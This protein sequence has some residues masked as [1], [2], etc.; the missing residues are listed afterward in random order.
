M[1]VEVSASLRELQQCAAWSSRCYESGPLAH[2]L[3]HAI[4]DPA[5]LL[6]GDRDAPVRACVRLVLREGTVFGA[7]VTAPRSDLHAVFA[8]AGTVLAGQRYNET[9]FCE[10]DAAVAMA[11]QSSGHERAR[12]ALEHNAILL[13]RPCLTLE[14]ISRLAL[15][16]IHRAHGAAAA[17]GSGSDL[18]AGLRGTWGHDNP[19]V[20]RY[21]AVLDSHASACCAAAPVSGSLAVYN[22]VAGPSGHARN[23]AQAIQ[24]LPWLLPMMTSH[25]SDR[26]R[27]EMPDILA[28]IDGGLPLLDAV[29]EAFDVQREVIR[30]LG[31]RTL[32]DNWL[33]DVRRVRR[34]L[35]L[36][37]WLPPERRPQTPA[38]WRSLKSLAAA[39]SA[40]LGYIAEI[41]LQVTLHRI[42]HCM[43]RWLAQTWPDDHAERAIELLDAQD[44]LRALFE[45]HQSIE[46][47][48]A[49]AADARVLS[50]CARI[51][52]ARVVALSRAWHSTIAAQTWASTT[53]DTGPRWPAVIE[54]PWQDGDRT[55][56]ELTSRE[57]LRSEGQAMAHC[58]GSYAEVCCSGNSVIVS[59][60]SQTGVALS[61]AELHLDDSFPRITAGQH[62]AALNAAPGPGCV[63]ALAALLC[64]LNRAGQ[65]GRL[66]R[67]REFQRAQRADCVC[68]SGAHRFNLFAQEMA[69]RLSSDAACRSLC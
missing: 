2:M 66:L 25:A 51:R 21:R 3:M 47:L 38:A 36:L 37:S 26:N 17:T 27:C 53:D 64:H 43:R 67:R 44:F 24:A 52:I 23:R 58:V 62:R 42:G 1:G 59:L 11:M 18:T 13:P 48:D 33:V 9:A 50:W 12:F 65:H 46:G 61:T 22:F 14:Q 28:A 45:S 68:G 39:L 34:L 5:A 20:E 29:A 19:A 57:E 4:V 8:L 16:S 6:R 49:S 56:V 60:R 31:R 55:I 40:P 10:L 54:S 30:W 35:T 63:R 41:D 32:P 15:Q 69:L 7:L